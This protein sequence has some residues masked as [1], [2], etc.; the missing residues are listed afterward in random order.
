MCFNSRTNDAIT[1]M[2]EY[3]TSLFENGIINICPEYYENQ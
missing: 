2:S 1:K 3:Y